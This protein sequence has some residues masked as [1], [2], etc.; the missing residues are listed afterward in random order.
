MSV[1]TLIVST[2][3]CL[4]WTVALNA[5]TY[6]TPE[7]KA[8]AEKEMADKNKQLGI[9]EKIQSDTIKEVFPLNPPLPDLSA[10]LT[11]KKVE[12]VNID[13]MHSAEDIR[14]FKKEAKTEFKKYN[15]KI[16]MSEKKLYFINRSDPRHYHLLPFQL[17]N[18]KLKITCETCSIDDFILI[19]S[20]DAKIVIDAPAPD[21]GQHFFFRYT[22]SK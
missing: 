4:F 22:F 9:T 10:Y 15:G 2:A 14:R 11:L 7:L 19:E 5:Q 1:K 16:S 20:S 13:K 17:I 6:A 8:Q 12:V 18:N 3:V 21:E